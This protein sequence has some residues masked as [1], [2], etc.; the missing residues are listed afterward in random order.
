MKLFKF[1]LR[2]W[3]TFSSVMVF[4]VSWAI[5]GHSPKPIDVY[6]SSQTSASTFPT[7]EPLPPMFGEQSSGLQLS[8]Q[9]NRQRARSIFVTGAS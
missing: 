7:L 5:F 3:I 1:G 6:A 8:T 4:L 9:N 2:V